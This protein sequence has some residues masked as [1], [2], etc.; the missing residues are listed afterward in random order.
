MSTEPNPLEN[1]KYVVVAAIDRGSLSPRVLE[2]AFN[3]ADRPG[4]ELH[5]LGIAEPSVA[6]A[7]AGGAPYAAEITRVDPKDLTALVEATLTPVLEARVAKEKAEGRTPRKPPR[8]EV[9]TGFGA[10]AAEIVWFAAHVSAELIVVGTAGRRGFSRLLLG[11]VAEKVVRLAGC[12]VMVVRA[13]QH[14]AEERVPEI[15]PLC[16]MCADE[17]FKSGGKELWCARHREHHPRAHTYHFGST[18][19]NAP[20]STSSSTGD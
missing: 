17:R 16:P 1:A 15:E 6:P 9:H 12:P 5:I 14:K 13:T 11:S 8:V 19:D 4:G 3:A 20:H 2:A 18:L 7:F 10:P